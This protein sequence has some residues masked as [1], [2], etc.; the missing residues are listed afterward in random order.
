[1][2]KSN[3]KKHIFF[4]PTLSNDLP[5]RIRDMAIPTAKSKKKSPLLSIPIDRPYKAIKEIMPP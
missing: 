5:L 4:G 2:S 1:M 3:P